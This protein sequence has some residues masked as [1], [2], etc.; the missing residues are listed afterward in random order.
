MLDDRG[1]TAA[2]LLYSLTRIRSIART[3]GVNTTA[4]RETADKH[5]LLEHPK[6]IKLSKHLLRLYK[7]LYIMYT[8]QAWKLRNTL[9]LV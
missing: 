6:E 5:V 3:A 4:L 9:L 2:Y 1:K 8:L 7:Q